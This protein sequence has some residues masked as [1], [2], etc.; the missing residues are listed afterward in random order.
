M[1]DDNLKLKKEKKFK[2]DQQIE[3]EIEELNKFLDS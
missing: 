2:E 1:E 3:K